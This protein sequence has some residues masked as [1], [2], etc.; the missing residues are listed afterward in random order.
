MASPSRPIRVLSPLLGLGFLV[1]LIAFALQFSSRRHLAPVRLFSF[2]PT[3]VSISISFE[4]ALSSSY[5]VSDYSPLNFQCHA[6][7]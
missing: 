3:F 2:I 7:G 1:A 6:Y 4:Q 5:P